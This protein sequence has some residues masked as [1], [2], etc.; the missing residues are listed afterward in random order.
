VAASAEKKTGGLELTAAALELKAWPNPSASYF[1]IRLSSSSTAPVDIRLVDV[2]GRVVVQQQHVAATGNITLG[3]HL[4]TGV[5]YLEAQ[6]G[7]ERKRLKLVK[8]P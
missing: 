4:K 8:M 6:Q 3:H 5:Y 7:A 2:M 1:T